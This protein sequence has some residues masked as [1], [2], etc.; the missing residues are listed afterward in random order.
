MNCC[1]VNMTKELQSRRTQ[2]CT[3]RRFC[4]ITFFF[5]G[6]FIS[7]HQSFL[8]ENFS[9]CLG[10]QQNA[11]FGGFI[12]VN[13]SATFFML[14][15]GHSIC[16]QIRALIRNRS[17]LVTV[18]TIQKPSLI[19]EDGFISACIIVR[20]AL[21]LYSHT[22]VLCSKIQDFF[23]KEKLESENI[24][25]IT[26]NPNTWLWCVSIENIYRWKEGG[27]ESKWLP[28]SLFSNTACETLKSQ[29]WCVK[30]HI[31]RVIVV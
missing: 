16:L 2:D 13:L 10:L 3:A 30:P 7:R 1:Y 15:C 8:L 14:H 17:V 5:K 25:C 23:F 20:F 24:K 12:P 21:Q 6:T 26:C 28:F 11:G 18:K 31:S 29:S 27:R 22:L 19:I 4:C 9:K